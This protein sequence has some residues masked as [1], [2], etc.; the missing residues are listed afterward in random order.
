[1]LDMI[2]ALTDRKTLDKNIRDEIDNFTHLKDIVGIAKKS[3]DL[4]QF[5]QSKKP[6]VIT[7][8]QKFVWIL[9]KIEKDPEL[10]KLK[11]AF[12]IDE[13]H[14][15][16]E[17]RM[18]VAI[19]TPFRN[20]EE[21]DEPEEEPDPEEEMAEIIRAHDLNQLFVAFTATPS[22]ETT[23]LF[24]DPFDTYSEAEAIAEGYIVDV[25]TSIISYET[26]YNLKSKVIPA[27]D[28]KV[29]P[30]GIISKALKNIAY[31]DEGLIQYKAEVMI[32]IFEENIKHLINGKAKVMIVTTSRLAGLKYY[33]IFQAKLKERPGA[34]YKVLYAFSDFTN[35]ETGK[36]ITEIGLN[37]LDAG[38]LIEDRF[39]GDDYRIL[40][41][42]N[43][44]QTGFDQP[45]LA[46][47]FLD[48]P[49]F[50]KNA[51]QT[52][53]RL[54]RQHEG[55]DGV[56]VVDFTNNAHAIL[57]AFNKYR[58]GTPFTGGTP[59]EKQC[60]GYYNEIMKFGIFEQK[61]AASIVDLIAARDDAR[62]Q[63]AVNRLR[64][65]FND[66]LT[67]IDERKEFVYLM[68]KYAKSYH[69][70]VCFFQ[71]P[72]E[73]GI[74][75]AFADYVGPQLIK[76]GTVSDL[77]RQVRNST[78]VKAS[79]KYKGEYSIAGLTKI[80]GGKI[81]GGGAPPPKKVTVQDVINEITQRYKIT[82]EEALFIRQVTEEKIQDPDIQK[83]ITDNK[84][85]IY[86]LENDYLVQVNYSIQDSYEE[87]R[88]YEELADP[89]YLEPGAIFD[90][91]ALSVIHYSLQK[92]GQEA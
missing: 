34:D 13:A 62:L 92:L 77:M 79:V 90:T 9:S 1:M 60:V 19:R 31:Q 76:R 85:D 86:F 68:A 4:V 24:G 49:V 67:T 78:V 16:Q 26:L 84:D 65:K 32:R 53:S 46:G 48:K 3:E 75:A 80:K 14:R 21:P 70:L 40:I 57:K 87:K 82:D 42:A 11:V 43:K 47:M 35:P 52:V 25:A 56:V 89:K 91:M 10:K 15:S 28:E 45:L 30:K 5:M 59:D 17:G 7:T 74:F 63:F 61:D 23:Q 51:V 27:E 50:E 18:G 41:V 55:K 33:E 2:F 20:P 88:R 29:Y 83:I 58:Q 73:H 71:Y 44:F 64:T 72:P 37:G 36:S 54:N 22:Q 39:E 38:E 12:L 6:I 69:F 81:G 66:T 8:Q